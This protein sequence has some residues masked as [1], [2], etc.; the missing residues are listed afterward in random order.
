MQLAWQILR[1][2]GKKKPCGP[3][4]AVVEFWYYWFAITSLLDSGIGSVKID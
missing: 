2:M 3:D 4:D 1:K